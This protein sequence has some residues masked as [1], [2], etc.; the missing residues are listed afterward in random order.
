MTQ[1]VLLLKIVYISKYQY[2]YIQPFVPYI[3]IYIYIYCCTGRYI[4]EQNTHTI[5][6]SINIP[7]YTYIYIYTS[8]QTHRTKYCCTGI[9]IYIYIYTGIYIPE[10]VTQK[11]IYKKKKNLS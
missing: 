2:L 6:Y 11:M 3:Y 5:Y 8:E 7:V 1:I 4:P 9:H 10:Q